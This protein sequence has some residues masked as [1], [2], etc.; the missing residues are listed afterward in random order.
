MILISE[1]HLLFLFKM[2]EYLEDLTNFSWVKVGMNSN[3]TESLTFYYSNRSTLFLGVIQMR[4]KENTRLK[5]ILIV[6][7]ADTFPKNK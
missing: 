7:I 5:S 6:I 3:L 4:R 2:I 1:D